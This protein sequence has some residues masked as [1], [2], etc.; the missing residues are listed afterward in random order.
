M[1]VSVELFAEQ[2]IRVEGTEIATSNDGVF[3]YT[4]K[5]ITE[6]DGDSSER[7]VSS[8]NSRVV[9]QLVHNKG[10]P[11]PRPKE[12]DPVDFGQGGNDAVERFRISLGE[13]GDLAVD[14]P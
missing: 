11:G 4:V 1:A 7:A 8:R 9:I 12:F 5:A 3:Y 14:I 2:W 13:D 6:R 10:R